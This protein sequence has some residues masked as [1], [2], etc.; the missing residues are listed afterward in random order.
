LCVELRS[1]GGYQP[2]IINSRTNWIVDAHGYGKRFIVRGDEILAA[3]L[4]SECACQRIQSRLTVFYN[5]PLTHDP[6]FYDR[7]SRTNSRP[8]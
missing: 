8:N 7:R 3:F 4:E 6:A 2:F 5:H 1:L